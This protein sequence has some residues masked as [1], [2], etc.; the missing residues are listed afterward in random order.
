[1][2][3]KCFDNLQQQEIGTAI[4]I[5][6]KTMPDN[7]NAEFNFKVIQIILICGHYLSKWQDSVHENCE[8]CNTV[9][10]IPHLLFDCDLA[11]PIWKKSWKV[12]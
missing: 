6:I 9:H 12:S 1:M 10:Y 5:Q 3:K 11:Q 4:R 8:I 2:Y 7:K